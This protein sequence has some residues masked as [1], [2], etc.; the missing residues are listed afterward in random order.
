MSNQHNYNSETFGTQEEFRFQQAKYVTRTITTLLC[1]FMFTFGAVCLVT[2]NNF[3]Y[4]F[5]RSN[6]MSLIYVGGFGG[7]AMALYITLSARK[8]ERQL[9]IFTVLETMVVCAASAMYGTD[10]MVM[11]MLS[12]FVICAGLGVYAMTTSN[13]HLSLFPILSSGLTCFV[14]ISIVNIFIGAEILHTINLYIGTV[15]FIGYIIFDVQYFLCYRANEVA[16]DQSDLHIMAA[17]NIY[18]DVINIFARLFLEIYVRLQKKD[19]GDNNDNINR[20]H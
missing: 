2:F 5:V 18:V 16:Y 19:D 11:A 7:I 20:R 14:F 10:V 17:F 9:A 6:I 1:Q 4:H 13:N 8:T 3:A 12:T 15:L